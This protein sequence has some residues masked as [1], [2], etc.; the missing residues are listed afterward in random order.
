MFHDSLLYFVDDLLSLSLLV[1][2]RIFAWNKVRKLDV[3][4]FFRFV[5]KRGTFC[6]KLKSW[7]NSSTLHFFS[8]SFTIKYHYTDNKCFHILNSYILFL[9]SRIVRAIFVVSKTFLKIQ[10]S[11]LHYFIASVPFCLCFVKRL[12]RNSSAKVHGVWSRKIDFRR[13][14]TLLNY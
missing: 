6:Q 14:V 5:W 11:G 10:K 8:W 13:L 1:G 4:W 12:M 3:L 9:C 7:T 2:K